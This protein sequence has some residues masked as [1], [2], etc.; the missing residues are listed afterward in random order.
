MSDID[1][2][3]RAAFHDAAGGPTGSGSAVGAGSASGVGSSSGAPASGAADPRAVLNALAARVAAGDRGVV[4]HTAPGW[5]FGRL[6]WLGTGAGA[7]VVAGVIGALIGTSTSGVDAAGS[8]AIT[9][10]AVPGA[11]SYE[12]P[13]GPVASQ[14]PAGARVLAV[15]R[16]EDGSFIAVRDLA[17][18]SGT[19]WLRAADLTADPDQTALTD[20]PVA[21]GCPV[22][23]GVPIALATTDAPPA[24]GSVA[25]TPTTIEPSTS[26][27][28]TAESSTPS[29]ASTSTTKTSVT[30]TTTVT[31]T[32]A[33]TSTTTKPTKT[34][35]PAKTS[36]PQPTKT[37]KPT[38]TSTPAT[39]QAPTTST[40][41]TPPT[42]TT[43]TAPPA[44]TTSPTI[45]SISLNPNDFFY[46]E[47]PVTIQV[48]ASDDT[49]VTGVTLSWSGAM[50]GSTQMS[51]VNGRG[52]LAST[53]APSGTGDGPVTFTAV[54]RDAA[55]NTSSPASATVSHSNFG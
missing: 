25:N 4:A 34:T 43:T 14:V 28:S 11:L 31:P 52:W 37:T 20:L 19:I 12:C 46:N 29:E 53:R 40:S 54:A 17:D 30:A 33:T 1:D 8:P 21:A 15:G 45:S 42:T 2:V 18:Y 9:P 27:S 16:S 32:T 55:G 10:A 47:E 6:A 38:K 35:K 41:S 5:G 23:E 49:A 3:L 26:E 24:S 48:S 50:S 13:D 44:D 36:K 51:F 39:S 7:V 22:V